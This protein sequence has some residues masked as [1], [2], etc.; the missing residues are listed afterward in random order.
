MATD[1]YHP[2]VTLERVC[3]DGV[4]RRGKTRGQARRDLCAS[5]VNQASSKS[6]ALKPLG[7][8]LGVQQGQ[9]YCSLDQALDAVPRHRGE[10]QGEKRLSFHAQPVMPRCPSAGKP[11]LLRETV[12]YRKGERLIEGSDELRE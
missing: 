12:R 9:L 1:R 5:K 11:R 3:L 7:E 10:D 6:P 4:Q 2:G 8:V